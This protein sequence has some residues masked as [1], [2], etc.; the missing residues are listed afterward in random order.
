MIW[1]VLLALGGVTVF[2]PFLAEY[3]RPRMDRKLQASAPGSFADLSKGRVHY[4]WLGAKDG[5]VAVCV[6]GLSTPSFVWGSVAEH[7]GKMGFRVLVYDH[8]G[9]GFSDRPKG[10]QDSAFFNAQLEELLDHQGVKDDVTL[11]GY[12]MGGAVVTGFAAEHT[13]RVRQV[14]LIAPA[15]LKHDLGPVSNLIVNYERFGAWVAYAFYARSLRQGVEA[16]RGT[17]TAIPNMHDMQI[18][19]TYRRGFTPAMLSSLRGILDEDLEPAHRTIAQA[20]LPIV[21]I[22]GED[23]DVIPISGRDTLAEWNPSAT[24][25][26][27]ANAGHSITY[28]HVDELANALRHLKA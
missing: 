10:D 27:I 21:A 24:Q 1:W 26:V 16:E 23:D 17:P 11:I 6:H 25:E 9:R 2:G 12:S 3:V 18:A 22:W 20:D 4:Q 19:E 5:P 14:C 7:L 13:K 28:T 15:G 8:Y